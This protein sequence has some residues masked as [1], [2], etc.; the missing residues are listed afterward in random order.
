MKSSDDATNSDS[1]RSQGASRALSLGIN[2]V[3]GV[4]LFTFLG[5]SIDKHIGG[6][7]LWTLLG[8]VLGV[9][10]MVYEFWKVIL[11]LNKKPDNDKGFDVNDKRT[12]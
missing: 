12:G 1:M 11:L 2:V 3:A 4:G 5:Y 8:F 10:Y 6:G 9:L 7:I